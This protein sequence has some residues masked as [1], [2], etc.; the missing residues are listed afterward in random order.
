MKI[1]EQT[2]D[3]QRAHLTEG[4]VTLLLMLS[5]S[6]TPIPVFAQTQS[7]N[8]VP[9]WLSN[10]EIRQKWAEVPIETARKAAD[11]GDVTA[12]DYLGTC[13]LAG[14]QVAADPAVAMSWF[15]RA[16]DA[17]F[18]SSTRKMGVLYQRGNGVA[19]DYARA[20]QLYRVAADGGDP[21]GEFNVGV[22]FRDGLGVPRDLDEA[23]KWFRRSAE[24]GQA[25]AMYELYLHYQKFTGV[26]HDPEE[27]RKW[28]LQSAESGSGTGQ[29]ELGYYNEFRIDW[30][31]SYLVTSSNNMPEAVRWYRLS[32][33]QGHAGGQFH[34]ALCYLQGKGVAQDEE[35][36]LELI[37]KSA[38][39]NHK[40]A[41]VKLA[42]LYARGIGQPKSE[43]DRP[44]ALLLRAGEAGFVD[45]WDA[46]ASR[47]Q[48]GLGTDR[49]L[50][51]A[52][53]W[54]CR[55]VIAA[56]RSHPAKGGTFFPSADSAQPRDPYWQH[57]CYI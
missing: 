8:T 13:Y 9:R 55:G 22:V 15:R 53:G 52:C 2:R 28:L 26:E 51:V 54:Y 17:G 43:Q 27:A 44:M 56:P 25:D 47:Y 46:L 50:I 23:M 20:L 49:D 18:L 39:Q 35:R 48:N 34:L 36:G 10:K 31:P 14:D 29:C 40:Y 45:A 11:N 5:L 30:D 32:A 57:G 19:Q 12:Q 37:R 42:D 6:F 1:I 4:T 16:S 7:T 38:D 41:L 33:D 21:A 24:H 3:P